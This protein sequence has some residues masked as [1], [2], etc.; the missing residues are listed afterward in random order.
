M[1][2]QKTTTQFKKAHDRQAPDNRQSVDSQEFRFEERVV[3]VNRV[4]KVVKG[5]RRFSFTAIVVVGDGLGQV[6][7]G[8]GK[9]REV[10]EAI[11]KATDDARKNIFRIPL[12]GKTIPH[13]VVGIFG[14]ARVLLKPAKEGSGVR[15]GLTVRPVVEL[16]GIHDIVGKSQR[17]DTAINVVA[18]TIDALKRLKD[19]S[20]V[21]A[22]RANN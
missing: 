2:D 7:A 1:T 21:A 17:S 15:A 14:A 8:Y 4:A 16:A 6:G 20:V 12:K 13:E 22:L 11:R 3:K 5:G 9:A 19:P 18:A 10:A